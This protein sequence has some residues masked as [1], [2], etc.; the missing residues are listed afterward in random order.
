MEAK[1]MLFEYNLYQS[2]IDFISNN[3]NDQIIDKVIDVYPSYPK[4]TKFVK[5][6]IILQKI[7]GKSSSIGIG[8]DIGQYMVGDTL[9][10]VKG[11]IHNVIYQIDIITGGNIDKLKLSSFMNHLL[12]STCLSRDVYATNPIV[13]PLNDYTTNGDGVE[14][15]RIYVDGDIDSN[16]LQIDANDDYRTVIRVG[17]EAVQTLILDYDIVDLSKP[18][19]WIQTIA[20]N[21]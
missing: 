15:G 3:I 4:V 14:I 13:I 2:L 20:N 5:P 9:Y 21:E 17:F 16:D 18:I 6:S 8:G 11:I 1:D 19:N 7:T 10:D 12:M